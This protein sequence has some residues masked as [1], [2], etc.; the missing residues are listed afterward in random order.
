MGT[1]TAQKPSEGLRIVFFT[2]RRHDGIIYKYPKLQCH[3]Y[4]HLWG[5]SDLLSQHA[6]CSCS[7]LAMGWWNEKRSGEWGRFRAT[8]DLD[9]F[10]VTTTIN[11]QFYHYS[12]LHFLR[13]CLLYT[14][15]YHPAHIRIAFHPTLGT[16]LGTAQPHERCRLHLV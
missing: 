12:I 6:Q 13:T 16:H 11:G 4:V 8:S 5:T 1:L 14:S 2:P 7:N 9:T 10:A 15:W 3:Q